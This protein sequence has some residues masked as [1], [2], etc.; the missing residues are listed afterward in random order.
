M[1]A[2]GK[3]RKAI[4][5][6]LRRSPADILQ[7]LAD[8]DRSGHKMDLEYARVYLDLLDDPDKALTYA[9]KEYASRP[10]NI[11]VNKALALIYHRMGNEEKP[12]TQGKSPPHGLQRPG[13]SVLTDAVCLP[14]APIF[15]CFFEQ[16][17]SSDWTGV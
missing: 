4:R 16:A 8:D 5:K 14:C 15:R 2:L 9:L 3:K 10:E 11:D 6:R 7:M 17:L 1:G 12:R 13:A